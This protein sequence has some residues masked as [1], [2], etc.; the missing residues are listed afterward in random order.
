MVIYLASIAIQR[1]KS[2]RNYFSSR[3]TLNV[4]NVK[5]QRNCRVLSVKAVVPLSAKNV[6]GPGTTLLAQNAKGLVKLSVVIVMGK[7]RLKVRGS[8]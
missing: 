3:I 2:K 6:M 5:E 7:V 1:V 4:L 8:S